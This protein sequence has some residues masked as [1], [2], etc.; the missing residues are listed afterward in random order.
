V[1]NEHLSNCNS[2]KT[3]NLF[4]LS[5]PT[6]N[7]NAPE[8]ADEGNFSLKPPTLFRKFEFF[9]FQFLIAPAK[10]SRTSKTPME[11]S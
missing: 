2:T 5:D 10:L 7:L 6:P 3:L 9:Y 8:E 1:I 11:N 4:K